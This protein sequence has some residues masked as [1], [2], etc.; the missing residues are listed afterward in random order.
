MFD[1]ELYRKI[2]H[3]II[4]DISRVWYFRKLIYAQCLNEEGMTIN[5]IAE[6]FNVKKQTAEKYLKKFKEIMESTDLETQYKLYTAIKTADNKHSPVI[7]NEIMD[8]VYE[9]ELYKE[10]W[11][12]KF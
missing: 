10:K 4:Y 1:H 12:F 5:E 7:I 8:Y 6:E 3:Q 2:S 11:Y 9:L